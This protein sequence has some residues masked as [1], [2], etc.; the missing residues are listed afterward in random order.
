MLFLKVSY[1]VCCKHLVTLLFKFNFV[2]CAFLLSV[3]L[4]ILMLQLL[5]PFMPHLLH[6]NSVAFISSPMHIWNHNQ[7]Q[8]SSPFSAFGLSSPPPFSVSFPSQIYT[9]NK[10]SLPPILHW[11]PTRYRDRSLC[12]NCIY[13]TLCIYGTSRCEI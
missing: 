13:C 9:L 10:T 1:C 8:V 6:L 7:A 2:I 4:L 3:V 5:I 12:L 11:A